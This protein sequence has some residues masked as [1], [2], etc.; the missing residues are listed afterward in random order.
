[1]FWTT[2][3]TE[4]FGIENVAEFIDFERAVPKEFSSGKNFID[5]YISATKVLIEQKASKIDLSKGEKQS[6]GQFLT[7]YQQ[8]KR[9]GSNQNYSERPRWIIVSNFVSFEIHDM[10]RMDS[11]PYTIK[12]EDL[13]NEL[14]NLSMIHNT[15]KKEIKEE[16]ALSVEAGKIVDE[17][18][19]ILAK[20]YN[21]DSAEVQKSLNMLCVRLIFLLYA[22]DAE[23]FGR[24]GMFHDFVASYNAQNLKRCKTNSLL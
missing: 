8:A 15:G 13:P 5:G 3:L 2:L 14:H 18:Y 6:D 23:L 17:L 9:Y 16:M 21:D 10:D 12:L 7:P 1:M 20:E 24:K 22:D 19:E 11:E 4:V